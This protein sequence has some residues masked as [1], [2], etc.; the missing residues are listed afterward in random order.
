M[1]LEGA[2][3]RHVA[4]I[5]EQDK[6]WPALTGPAAIVE[7]PVDQGAL[8]YL[9]IPLVKDSMA[10]S[11]I[12]CSS[13]LGPAGSPFPVARGPSPAWAGISRHPDRGGWLAYVNNLDRK[14]AREVKL[15]STAKLSGIRNLTSNAIC[16]CLSRCRR[17]K[18]GS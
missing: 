7:I 14:E 10:S 3:V 11:W 6:C 8:Y 5:G 18:P 13:R 15:G 17:E 1:L 12:A 4:K 2:G 9:A 16:R